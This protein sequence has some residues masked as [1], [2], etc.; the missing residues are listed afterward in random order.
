MPVSNKIDGLSPA[1]PR[2]VGETRAAP[3]RAGADDRPVGAVAGGDTVKLTGHAEQLRELE[4]HIAGLPVADAQRVQD[5]RQALTDGSYRVD[6]AA[7]AA[8][9]LQVER[10]YAKA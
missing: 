1:P 4:R 3:R 9:L 8:K 2:G 5:V 6:P 7:I 10:S